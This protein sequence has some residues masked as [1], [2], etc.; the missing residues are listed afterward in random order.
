M[1]IA[2]TWL[3]LV[4]NKSI[5]DSLDSSF[6]T[7]LLRKT[8]I[9]L[10][11]PLH[12]HIAIQIFHNTGATVVR[13]SDSILGCKFWLVLKKTPALVG[14]ELYASGLYASDSTHRV[15]ITTSRGPVV[16][17]LISTDGGEISQQWGGGRGGGL[18]LWSLAGSPTIISFNVP[19]DIHWWHC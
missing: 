15:V 13:I 4:W 17:S 9:L 18:S 19:E 8:V 7:I 1:L 5:M 3:C 12:L 10:F 11:V 14:T 16:K 2:I 6:C